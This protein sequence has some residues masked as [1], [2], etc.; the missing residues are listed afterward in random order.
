MPIVK[1]TPLSEV[2]SGS[3]CI[4]S[5]VRTHELDKLRYIAELGLIPGVSFHLFSCAP[6]RGP[7][8]LQ[9]NT[10]DHV[11]GHEL[12]DSIWVEITKQGPG[13][14]LPP[15]SSPYKRHVSK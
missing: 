14:K 8:R 7:L 13:N 6:F 9:M 2:P 10:L 1:D 5:R 12:A 15:L 4:V 11:I 3:D